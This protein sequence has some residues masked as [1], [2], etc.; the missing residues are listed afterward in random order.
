M[1]QDQSPRPTLRDR[2][3]A[4]LDWFGHATRRRVAIDRRALA[5]FR[6]SLGV[7]LLVDLARRTRMLEEFY[8]DA[9]VLP[10]EALFADY[11]SV[12]S[13]HALSGEA[14]VQGLLFFIAGVFALALLCGYHTRIAA[15]VSWLLLI[16]LHIRN[17]MVLNAGDILLR[18]L[19]FWSLFLPLGSRWSIDARQREPNLGRSETT[20]ASVA[21]MAILLQVLLMYLTNAVHKTR[22]EM[23]MSGEAVVHIFQADHLT[24][25]LGNT[26][27]G[28]TMLL[29]GFTYAWM[30]LIVLSPLLLLLTGIPRAVLTTLFVGM[31]LGMLV[32]LRIDLFPVIVV[33]GLLLFYPPVVWDGVTTMATRVGLAAPTRGGLDRLATMLPATG[34]LLS[35]FEPFGTGETSVRS[36]VFARSRVFFATIIP[37]LIL[38]LVVLSNAEAVDY[39]EV[40]DPGDEVLDTIQSSQSWRMFA[41]N[42]TSTARWLV[43]PGELADGS[44]VD[45]LHES[46]VDWDRP[47]SVDE[48]Y[49]TARERKYISNMRYAN[50]ENHRSYFAN[51]LCERWNSTHETE[52]ERLTIYGMSDMSGPYDDEPDVKEF[53]LI[54]YD[55][56][57]EFIQN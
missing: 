50:N 55:C 32:T 44:T 14:W 6:I 52:L 37:W 33:S 21:T 17:P 11:S 42:P 8:T 57:G 7:L 18:M 1:S 35:R 4:G 24:F 48:T 9:G 16:S 34:R 22:S 20:L 15:V 26:L 54:E 40:P 23:W 2:L 46:E 47:P 12:Y 31:H 25:L 51:H 49:E 28:H 10:R 13:L 38:V 43:V 30:V 3:N 39:T 53:E 27:A 45:A 41:P 5:A 56:S 29:E 36:A 19:L